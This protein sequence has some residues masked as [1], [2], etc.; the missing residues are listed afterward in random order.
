MEPIFLSHRTQ[1]Q[2]FIIAEKALLGSAHLSICSYTLPLTV[3]R[4]SITLALSQIPQCV[5]PHHRA[6]AHVVPLIWNSL[7][8]FPQ[9]FIT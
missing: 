2:T 4:D 7:L 3:L 8:S 5:L 9:P 6:P 1:S